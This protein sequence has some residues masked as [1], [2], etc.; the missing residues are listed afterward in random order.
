M[1][2]TKPSASGAS[3]EMYS[4]ELWNRQRSGSEA[5][6]RLCRGGGLLGSLAANEPSATRHP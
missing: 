4:P 2:A 5:T 6:Q 1:P 3:G